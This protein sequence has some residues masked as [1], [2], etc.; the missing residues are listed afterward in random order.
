MASIDRRPELPPGLLPARV[1]E[2]DGLPTVLVAEMPAAHSVVVDVFVPAGPAFETRAENGISHFL[3][4]AVLAG[5]ERF[6]DR[7]SLQAAIDQTGGFL[8]ALTYKEMTQ[9]S[10]QVLP[11]D[12]GSALGLLGEALTRPLLDAAAVESE[13]AIV[14][15][16]MMTGSYEGAKDPWSEILW[17]TSS[18]GLPII[19]THE[20]VS[21]L[22][23]AALRRYWR[24]TYTRAGA[25]VAIAGR[26]D[27]GALDR[28]LPGLSGFS[29]EAASAPSPV[30]RDPSA[31]AIHIE[32]IGSGA[33]EACL[34][35]RTR[36]WSESSASYHASVALM[37]QYLQ[38]RF[39]QDLVGPGLPVYYLYSGQETFVP[40]GYLYVYLK[41]T[42]DR[43]F[44]TL[45]RVM[46]E[47]DAV[48]AKGVPEDALALCKRRAMLG[49]VADLDDPRAVAF[50]LGADRLRCGDAGAVSLQG[51]VDALASVAS[52]DMNRLVAETFRS[53]K[54][55]VVARG[56]LGWWQRRRLERR[57]DSWLG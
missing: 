49:V 51:E 7:A 44:A 38:L 12:L 39:Y 19:G 41:V 18:V 34:M 1:L 31:S 14:L 47:L 16:E 24:R 30:T 56:Q 8:E 4:H 55:C 54:L 11:A 13:R 28:G 17:G 45:E 10:F 6:R 15:E 43:F 42:A 2:H 20:I 23:S 33:V 32:R 57:L 22:D 5:T 37:V 25:V 48:R 36:G 52:V 3:E 35:F 26:I 29:P 53:D 9:F 46:G 40:E 50:R 27:G 21:G